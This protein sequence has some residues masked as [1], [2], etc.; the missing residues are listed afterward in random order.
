MILEYYTRN[1]GVLYEMRI[2]IP[3]FSRWAGFCIFF[4]EVQ[5]TVPFNAK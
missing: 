2:L 1:A 4:H 3:A 5:Y